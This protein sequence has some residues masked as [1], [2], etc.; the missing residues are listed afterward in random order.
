M[1]FAN[2]VHL[3]KLVIGVDISTRL[4]RRTGREGKSRKRRR[5]SRVAPPY[6]SSLE[7]SMVITS[8]S[9]SSSSATS[10]IRFNV[11]DEDEDVSGCFVFATIRVILTECFRVCLKIV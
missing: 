9:I 6:S 10:T 7:V 11:E 2:S 3:L 4:P 5:R 8:Y 1:D